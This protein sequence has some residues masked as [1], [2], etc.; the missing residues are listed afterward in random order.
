MEKQSAMD[1]D[2][3]PYI[4]IQRNRNTISS[5]YFAATALALPGAGAATAMRCAIAFA[6]TPNVCIFHSFFWAK[7]RAWMMLLSNYDNIVYR[8]SLE[9]ILL[10]STRARVWYVPK[11]D[12]WLLDTPNRTVKVI[13]NS[14]LDTCVTVSVQPFGSYENI[15]RNKFLRWTRSCKKN[16]C[17]FSF[18]LSLR[19]IISFMISSETENRILKAEFQIRI[20][21]SSSKWSGLD[22]GW[23]RTPLKTYETINVNRWP[24]RRPRQN[25]RTFQ[26]PRL[27]QRGKNNNE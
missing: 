20:S 1:G 9:K 11:T 13:K 25:G 17:W 5:I 27:S 7:F 15:H 16:E 26:I 22:G 19:H 4:Q 10:A 12:V 18:L 21:F 3:M 2:E 14:N 23:I 24:S 8:C 6:R